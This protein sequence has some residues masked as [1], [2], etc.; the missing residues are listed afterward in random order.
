MGMAGLSK[1]RLER[2]HQV[3]NGC[4]RGIFDQG[5]FNTIY[6]L[7]SRHGWPILDWY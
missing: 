4:Q 6:T 1:P 3:L 2:M 7:N 5:G